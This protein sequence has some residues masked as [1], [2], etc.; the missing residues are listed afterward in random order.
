MPPSRP[1]VIVA[2]MLVV[3][4]F[5]PAA[6]AAVG[7]AAAT[8]TLRMTGLS[9]VSGS[10]VKVEQIIGDHDWAHPTTPTASL[11]LTA[12][13]VLGNGLGYSFVSGDSTIFLFGDTIGASSQYVPRWAAAVD[14][15]KWSAHDPIARTHSTDPSGPLVVDF[16]RTAGDT[17]LT[18]RPAYPDG[19]P[20]PMGA[21]AIPNSGIDLGGVIDLVCSTGT[22]IVNGVSSHANDSSVVVRFDPDP[23]TFTAGR[24]MSRA[25]QG[26]H[27]VF[28]APYALPMQFA[29]SS[30]DTEVVVFGLGVYRQSDIYLSMIKRRLFES[31]VHKD[32]TPATRYFT[33]LVNGVPAWSDT[34]TLAVPV[35]FDDP[36]HE[37]GIGVQQA[38]WP[39][40]D[41]TIG[42]LSVS[43]CPAV[44]LW[45]M[46]FD[47]G[48]QSP[49]ASLR[50]QT[51]GVYFSYAPAPWG[52]WMVPQHIFNDT[53]DGAF[54]DYIHEYDHN[55][56]IGIGPAGPTIGDQQYNDPDTTSG[57]GFAPEIIERFT[58]LSGDTLV[59]EWALSTWNPYSVVRMRSK[60]LVTPGLALG[61]GTAT[62]DVA[63]ALEV[64]PDP[65]SGPVRI[66]FTLARPGDTRLEVLDVQGRRVRTLAAGAY[67]AGRAM[68]GWDGRDEAGHAAPAG[69]YLVRL[70][71]PGAVRVRRV[72][73]LD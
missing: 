30:T 6:R 2:A 65:A 59:L 40:D 23:Q 19:T 73:R 61:A 28:T 38:P 68:R 36:L 27:F 49:P 48:R 1:A 37:I 10:T 60:F 11:T 32:G 72:V 16:L 15:F 8:D 25:G 12:A 4:P 51:D 33:G 20:L 56:G 53:R 5:A 63:P 17:T 57:G 35:V 24:T 47:G 39:N 58:H 46:T 31:G 14:S 50:K 52:P 67:P 71:T 62:P 54:G 43:W 64:W 18:V 45:L 7:A 26:G 55:T 22:T 69:V 70:R 13:D 29:S 3:M 66:A 42:N 44:G 21:D 34:E 9:W 41:P